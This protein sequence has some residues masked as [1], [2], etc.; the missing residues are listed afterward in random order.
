MKKK[1]I[2]FF[3]CIMFMAMLVP[4]LTAEA[5]A[6]PKLSVKSKSIYVGKQYQLKLKNV[7]KKAKVKW[8]T[9]KKSVVS[10]VKKKGNTVTLKAK[11]K[12]TATITATYKKK[13]YKCK[14]T[15]KQKAKEKK[16]E[17]PSLNA[18]EISLYHIG[19]EY[20][21]YIPNTENHLRQFQFKVSGTSEKVWDWKITGDTLFFHISDDGLLT[22]PTGP[23]S[24]R[25]YA[26]V[27]VEAELYSGKKL[28]ATVYGYSE[29]EIFIKKVLADFEKEYIT[30]DMTEYEKVEK[31]AWY[32]G[33]FS[34]YESGNSSPYSLLIRG[35]GDCMASRIAVE[36]L[37]KQ[38]GIKAV[39][40]INFEYHGKTLVKIGGTYYMV[41]TG[42]D[43]PKPRGYLIYEVDETQLE[44]IMEDN[45]IFP[46]D[47]N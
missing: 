41:V 40:C 16:T 35:K 30:P 45:R 22:M 6:K 10:I 31:V 38:I 32:V 19:D 46:I 4:G 25:E 9:S 23:G 44:K 12:G 5:K 27:T 3:L 26:K 20:V 11:K 14:I 18:T 43:E 21:S 8:K 36:M 29:I 33:A 2:I 24:D 1:G 17:N 34:D 47:F 13:K 28:T 37:C 15:V 42:Y 7:S 39:A